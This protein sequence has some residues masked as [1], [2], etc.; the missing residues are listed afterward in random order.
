MNGV[1]YERGLL[2]TWSVVNVICNEHGLQGSYV[3][4]AMNVVSYECGRL[5]KWSAMNVVCNDR[6]CDE[7][8]LS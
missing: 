3:I 8:G 4:S 7:R 1:C 5:L 2:S 6:V